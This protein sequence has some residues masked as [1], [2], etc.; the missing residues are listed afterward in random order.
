MFIAKGINKKIGDFRLKNITLSVAD[1]E[2][3]SIIG[4]SGAGKSTIVKII[5]GIIS[6]EGK[7]V[8]DGEDI[9]KYPPEK[10]NIGYIPQ[11]IGLF[12][13]FDVRGNIEYPLKRR[14]FPRKEREKLI[15]EFSNEFGIDKLLHRNP[16]TLSGG[17]KQKVAL[18][19]A[20]IYSPK[21]LLMDEPLSSVDSQKKDFYLNL[22]KKKKKRY[23]LSIIYVTHNFDEAITISDKIVV[24]KGGKI[25]RRGSPQELIENP[26]DLWIA[27]FVKEKNIFKGSFKDGLFC[28]ENSELCFHTPFEKN[29]EGFL[30]LRADEIIISRDKFNSSALNVFKA[31]VKEIVELNYNCQIN[32]EV[33]GLVFK[34][35]ITKNSLARLRLDVGEEIFLHFKA[36]SLKELKNNF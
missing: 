23:E 19:R 15:K 28:A 36:N 11:N 5:T 21:L 10:R 14:K 30:S 12:P 35:I 2:I 7:L 25:I 3:L 1:R 33:K 17:E 6:S 18:V 22:I 29:G 4:P 9:S 16:L 20:L 24:L 32:A 34:V 13:H 27:S 8:L 31:R 26:E